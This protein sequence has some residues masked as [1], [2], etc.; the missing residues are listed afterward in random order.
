M[1]KLGKCHAFLLLL[2]PLILSFFSSFVLSSLRSG[3]VVNVEGWHHK[4]ITE[5]Q[6]NFVISH[7]YLSFSFW[8]HAHV[9]YTKSSNRRVESTSWW[10]LIAMM[11][12]VGLSCWEFATYSHTTGCKFLEL[13]HVLIVRISQQKRPIWFLP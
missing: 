8:S 6:P 9:L 5:V 4:D 13:I 7:T 1:N 12:R 3:F 10:H 2:R 11:P